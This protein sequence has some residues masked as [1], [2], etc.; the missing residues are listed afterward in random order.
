MNSVA[1]VAFGGAIGSVLRYLMSDWAQRFSNTL[2]PFGTLLVNTFGC[3][4]MGLCAAA[5][6]GVYTIKEEY[7]IGIMVGV[8]GG[9]TTFS[10]YGWESIV[11]FNNGEI[12]KAILNILGN[13]LLGLLAV[14]LGYRLGHLVFGA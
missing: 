12:T 11:L 5:F 10:S 6:L 3:L 14:W 7:R 2:F 4:C 9:Y 1:F 8:L 13:N